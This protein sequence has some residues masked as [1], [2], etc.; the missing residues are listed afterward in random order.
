MLVL[1]LFF[2]KALYKL[3]ENFI[4]G[5]LWLVDGCVQEW[6]PVD[7]IKVDPALSLTLVF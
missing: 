5:C 6:G 7:M 4:G 1:V 3:F 2:F